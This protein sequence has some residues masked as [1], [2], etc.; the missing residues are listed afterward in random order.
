M[1]GSA[2]RVAS[3]GSLV[4]LPAALRVEA[5]CGMMWPRSSPSGSE[6]MLGLSVVG[7]LSNEP[8]PFRG[9]MPTMETPVFIPVPTT[10][11]VYLRPRCDWSDRRPT[12]PGR[13][14]DLVLATAFVTFFP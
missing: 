3:G 5:G 7:W 13:A 6:A 8:S 14:L 9:M 11:H 12:P 1:G 2:W 4:D 10:S